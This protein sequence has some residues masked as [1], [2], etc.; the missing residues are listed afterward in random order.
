MSGQDERVI[1][2]RVARDEEALRQALQAGD[3]RATDEATGRLEH[4]RRALT[5]A[6]LDDDS[7]TEPA[8]A[9]PAGAHRR[10]G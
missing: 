1:R 9:K 6:G 10:R 8:G 3:G 7:L 5:A 4:A 2:D